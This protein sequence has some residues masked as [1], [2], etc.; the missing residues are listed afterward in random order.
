MLQAWPEESELLTPD[1]TT[2]TTARATPVEA[3]AEQP[4]EQA[5]EGTEPSH[6]AAMPMS[7]AE[8]S[9]AKGSGEAGTVEV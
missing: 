3:P 5:A 8:V 1:P 4:A 7:D 6:C 2:A 9:V